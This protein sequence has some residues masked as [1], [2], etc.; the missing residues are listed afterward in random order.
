MKTPLPVTV[1]AAMYLTI[2]L[3][4]MIHGITTIQ[5]PQEMQGLPLENMPVSLPDSGEYMMVKDSAIISTLITL[6]TA[7]TP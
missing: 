4:L 6:V 3:A 7:L 1:F 2:G 5:T